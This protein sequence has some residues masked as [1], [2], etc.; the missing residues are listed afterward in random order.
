MRT[1]VLR[2]S[3]LLSSARALSTKHTITWETADHGVIQLT[4]QEGELLRT[5]A[6]REGVVSPHNG[7]ANLINCRG[8]G[9]CG[10]CAVEI[11]GLETP[12][13]AIERVRL[14]VPPGHGSSKET[15]RLACQ[16]Q[17]TGDL[18]V[19]KY[20]GFWGQ[21]EVL[22]PCSVPTLPFGKLEYLLDT[23]SPSES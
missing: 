19:R 6:L 12:R 11:D 18:T 23:K 13:N 4:A 9:T 1:R 21:Y 8:L 5:A 22:A 20:T 15:L 3:F 7:R 17:V 10:T 16:V 2:L 14:T